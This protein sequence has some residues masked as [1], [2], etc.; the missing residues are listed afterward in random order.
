MSLRLRLTGSLRLTL[1][2]NC[3]HLGRLYP[4]R[5]LGRPKA[6]DLQLIPRSI[7]SFRRHRRH[8][9]LSRIRLQSSRPSARLLSSRSLRLRLTG[10]LRPFRAML[11]VRTPLASVQRPARPPLI[12][13]SNIAGRKKTTIS[14]NLPLR[15]CEL[16]AGLEAI[17]RADRRRAFGSSSPLCSG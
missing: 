8:L 12:R 3:L 1:H 10:P 11:P 4:S 5:H 13:C 2:L 6:I 9:S 17:V 7:P 15:P 16:L 14:K